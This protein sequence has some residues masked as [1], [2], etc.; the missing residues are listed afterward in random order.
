AR[1]VYRRAH[2]ADDPLPRIATIARRTARKLW[3]PALDD[4][5]RASAWTA[6]EVAT[7]LGAA[8][9][10]APAVYGGC[11]FQY[12]TGWRIGGALAGRRAAVGPGRGGGAGRR[13]SQA[14]EVGPVK[15]ASSLRPI[16]IP[17]QL[18]EYLREQPRKSEWV[19][20][21]PTNR[22]RH[23]RDEDYQEAWRKLRRS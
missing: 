20:P 3:A 10:D 12:S 17:Q 15:T 21:S 2:L 16:P 14:G 6:Q 13:G 9:Q 4:E 1:D 19:F 18:I 11:L 5:A 22:K 8:G 23:W 7:V